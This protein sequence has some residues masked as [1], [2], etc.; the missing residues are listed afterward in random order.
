[1][2]AP[3]STPSCFRLGGEDEQDGQ[4]ASE[5]GL[6]SVNEPAVEAARRCSAGESWARDAIG[7]LVIH[8]G[9]SR[10]APPVVDAVRARTRPALFADVSYDERLPP[11]S[12]PP[13]PPSPP[14]KVDMEKA[15]EI[16]SLDTSTPVAAG[17]HA[18][19]PGPAA[20]NVSGA[21]EEAD[22]SVKE[23]D[24]GWEALR[25]IGRRCNLDFTPKL[26]LSAGTLVQTLVSS[27]VG[28]YLEFVP[29]QATLMHA[30]GADAGV[31]T[32]ER[33]P[34]SKAEVFQAKSIAP[35]E[36]RLLMKFMQAMV[37]RDGVAEAKRGGWAVQGVGGSEQEQLGFKRAVGHISTP[38]GDD[39]SAGGAEVEEDLEGKTL[40]D[41]LR[42]ARL[43]PRVA[44]LVAHGL[45]AATPETPAKEAVRRF[46][47]YVRS[48]GR[49]ADSAMLASFYGLAE[50]L[51]RPAPH[52]TPLLA[53][54]SLATCL[55]PWP[56]SR[57]GAGL[58]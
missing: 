34:M 25:S 22:N 58:S 1:M 32:L 35:L 3:R 31:G 4:S 21:C 14:S 45:L 55:Y 47:V 30:A 44:A 29:L 19:A 7:R 10:G 8:D 52:T 53:L 33:V 51:S 50:E 42:E 48:L 17:E 24:E 11:V 6:A 39:G 23:N 37:A 18:E 56:N 46:G 54:A 38:A 2:F 41:L 27:G 43:P 49:Y 12:P 15:S 36:K 9:S 40:A 5:A 28:R 26:H 16:N 20:I 57:P 13:Q